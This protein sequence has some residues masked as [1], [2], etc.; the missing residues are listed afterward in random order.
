MQDAA[1]EHTSS[2]GIVASEVSASVL[3]A[4][5]ATEVL[6]FDGQDL[7]AVLASGDRFKL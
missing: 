5:E 6:D 2:E 4:S 1:K 3:A 7:E